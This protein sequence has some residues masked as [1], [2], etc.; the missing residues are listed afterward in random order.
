MRPI[1]IAGTGCCLLDYLYTGIDFN[2]PEFSRYLSRKE[3]DGGLSPGRLVLTDDL[4]KFAGKN[5]ENLLGEIVGD[6][7]PDE[8]NLGGPSIV[9]L[10]HAAQLLA[11][12]ASVRF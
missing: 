10:I 9:A 12:K 8:F 5:F 6:R 7:Q 3:G 2:G 11:N 4:E 1:T